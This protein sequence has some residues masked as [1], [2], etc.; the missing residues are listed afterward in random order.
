MSI[1]FITN[2]DDIDY[3]ITTVDMS[4]KYDGEIKLNENELIN[5][6]YVGLSGGNLR[7]IGWGDLHRNYN[8][9]IIITNSPNSPN[10]KDTNIDNFFKQ[11]IKFDE[12]VNTGITCFR[13]H[14]NIL[15]NTE[16]SF[17]S[18]IVEKK[19]LNKLFPNFDFNESEIV[20]SMFEMNEENTRKYSK[21][22]KNSLDISEI[23]KNIMMYNY[24]LGDRKNKKNINININ[25]IVDDLKDSDY[26]TIKDNLDINITDTFMDREFNNQRSDMR[27]MTVLVDRNNSSEKSKCIKKGKKEYFE[28]EKKEKDSK[29]KDS[30]LNNIKNN[31]FIDPSVV[32]RNKKDG[33]KRNFYASHIDS[34]YTKDDT[35]NL[36]RNIKEEKIKYD[37]INNLLVSKEYCHLILNNQKLLE[38]LKGMFDKYKNV[39]KYTFGYAWL[40]FYLEE[41]L[42]R[43]KTTKHSRFSFDI[44]TASKL[45]VFPFTYS[46]LKQNPYLTI[47][48]DDKEII[49]DNTYGL[50]YIPNHDGYGVCDINTFKRRFNIFTSQN[51]DIDPLKGLNWNKFAVSGSSVTA[52]LQKCS[53]LLKSFILECNGNED[54]AFNKFARKYYGESDIDLMTNETSIVEFLKSIGTV[55]DLLK[56]NLNAN[57][58]ERSY[59]VVKTFAV[60]ITEHFFTDYLEDFNKKYNLNV[61]KEEF[62]NM[63]DK[64]IFKLYIYNKYIENKNLHTSTL[65]TKHNIDVNDR[66]VQEFLIPNNYE[67]MNIYKVESK[68]YDNFAGSETEII[69][70]RNDLLTERKYND[71]D[72]K[73]VIKFSENFR[74]QL[75]CK[76]TNIEMFRVRDKEFFNTVARFHF[77]CVRSYY[78]GET[79]HLLPSCISAMMT[80]LNIEYKYFA[81]IRNPNEIVNKYVQRGFGVLLNKYERN[82]WVEYNKSPDNNVKEFKCTDETFK[83]LL[84]EKSLN[85]VIYGRNNMNTEKYTLED[86]RK[87][88][89]KYNV[90]DFTKMKTI[91]ENGNINKYCK[92]YVEFCYEIMN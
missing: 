3:G 9:V 77:P 79:V 47:L 7:E 20:L 49:S 13:T 70:R 76:N 41:C 62:E 74:F 26:W 2:D 22:Y 17:R 84:G 25:N 60:S 52:C 68:N 83:N 55:Y 34:T 81:G 71:E 92:S 54:E 16:H 48:I 29:E 63:T 88:Y 59:K 6:F 46:D 51:P 75:K 87:Y 32:I 82:I 45:P 12:L 64:I 58:N 80:G 57:E 38:E 18:N 4:V 53:P 21:F 67:N 28:D 56:Q 61:K 42:I 50:T 5:P 37:L 24:Y 30:K 39:F 14:I 27:N 19:Y 10:F 1:A 44:N 65:I 33:T 73:I 8:S 11:V 23:D 86:I 40:T 72:N 36:F 78:N 35:L 91:S 90:I 31:N 85:N 89:N 69:Y 43:T 15:D 66:F